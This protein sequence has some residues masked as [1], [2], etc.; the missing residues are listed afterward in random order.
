[1][2]NYSTDSL[3]QLGLQLQHAIDVDGNPLL[4]VWEEIEKELKDRCK[5]DRVVAGELFAF[6]ANA[7]KKAASPEHFN[8]LYAMMIALQAFSWPRSR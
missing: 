3:A 5:N 7:F 1:M 2:A 8:Q 4:S 6:H